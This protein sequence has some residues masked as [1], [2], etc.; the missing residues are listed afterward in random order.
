[1][2]LSVL[3]TQRLGSI[4]SVQARPARLH[5]MLCQTAQPQGHEANEG[6]RL[7][8][9]ST[10]VIVRRA[11]PGDEPSLAQLRWEWRA[12]ESGESGMGPA[13]FTGA[14]A[15]WVGQHRASH[16]AWVAEVDQMPVGMAWLAILDRIPGPEVW[17]RRSGSI[18]SVYV[19]P[20]RRDQG[21][22]AALVAAAIDEAVQRGLDYLVVHPSER[23]FPLYRR[24]GFIDHAGVLELRLH[25]RSTGASPGAVRPGRAG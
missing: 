10:T 1:M 17:E 5:A 23:S 9:P 6:I 22:G 21:I 25:P 13:E 16:L 11:G 24:A 15:E 19:R 14:F 20:E 2:S 7:V 12:M 8:P 18:Q 4:E 3:R